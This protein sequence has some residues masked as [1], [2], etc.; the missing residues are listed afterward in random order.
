M[1]R[2]ISDRPEDDAHADHRRKAYETYM[3]MC[4]RVQLGDESLLSDE[5]FK[6]DKENRVVYAIDSTELYSFIYQANIRPNISYTDRKKEILIAFNEMILEELLFSGRYE[7]ILLPPHQLELRSYVASF[8]DAQFADLSRI[9]HELLGDEQKVMDRLPKGMRAAAKASS[10]E[11]LTV[12]EIAEIL[13]EIHENAPALLLLARLPTA[14]PLARLKRLATVPFKLQSQVSRGR[15]VPTPDNLD[16]TF[17]RT[18]EQELVS[19]RSSYPRASNKSD[20]YALAYLKYFNNAADPKTRVRLVTRSEALH[21]LDRQLRD[22]SMIGKGPEHRL[23]RPR[24]FATYIVSRLIQREPRDM[25]RDRLSKIRLLREALDLVDPD[26]P[27]DI[28]PDLEKDIERKFLDIEDKWA[29]LEDLVIASDLRNSKARGATGGQSDIGRLLSF[30]SDGEEIQRAIA[31]RA[32]EV[33]AE[34]N[35]AHLDLASFFVS[36]GSQSEELL[37]KELRFVRSTKKTAED[38]GE[39]EP[40]VLRSQH[41][42]AQFSLQ[43]C[44]PEIKTLMGKAGDEKS[45]L[46]KYLQKV[47]GGSRYEK[48]LG[49]AFLTSAMGQWRLALSYCDA[50]LNVPDIE[51]TSPRHEAHYFRAICRRL[52]QPWTLP[53]IELSLRDLQWAR[54]IRDYALAGNSDQDPRYLNEEGVQLGIAR[55]SFGRDFAD[56][57]DFLS[58][59]ETWKLA[60]QQAVDPTLKLQIVNNLCYFNLERGAEGADSAAHYYGELLEI[61]TT[62]G[63]KLEDIASSI[64]HTVLWCQWCLGSR[65]SE[66][67]PRQTIGDELEKLARLKPMNE[68]EKKI[69]DDHTAIV[70]AQLLAASR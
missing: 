64:V 45:A 38:G 63:I 36:H 8:D 59:Q 13:D 1:T 55:S 68:S 22:R 19:I 47:G 16:R 10:G 18:C 48:L 28:C 26:R 17:L 37:K 51:D 15:P 42:Q 11:K 66:A 21:L 3:E 9:M 56:R 44:D 40:M 25:V 2:A 53:G 41:R 54:R 39:R 12:E 23:L 27:N 20:A 24:L 7:L 14:R 57:L 58:P 32:E 31:D 4:H 49:F 5:E 50:A 67:V 43:F 52:A 35:T 70:K 6:L 65:V 29:E 62:N 34:I 30:I 46:L 61:M 33:V 69:I 60:L